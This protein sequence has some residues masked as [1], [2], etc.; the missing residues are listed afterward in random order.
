[1]NLEKVYEILDNQAE[2]IGKSFDDKSECIVFVNDSKTA[3][4]LAKMGLNND[5]YY[6]YVECDEYGMGL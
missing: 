4:W 1:M 2:L 5:R 6:R 3:K